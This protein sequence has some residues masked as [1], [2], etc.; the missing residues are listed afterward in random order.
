MCVV[1]KGK[2]E[3]TK[4]NNNHKKLELKE[5]GVYIQTPHYNQK[6]ILKSLLWCL[7]L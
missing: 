3:K 2:T 1:C 4:I 6:V 7:T 5:T